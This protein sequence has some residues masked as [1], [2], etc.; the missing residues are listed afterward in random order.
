MAIV[1]SRYSFLVLAVI[2]LSS[3]GSSAVVANS[4]D[5]VGVQ[6]GM[7]YADDVGEDPY[8]TRTGDGEAV[9]NDLP[10]GSDVTLLQST[11]N[12]FLPNL[13]AQ[14]RTRDYS[15]NETVAFDSTLEL[16]PEDVQNYVVISSDRPSD[17]IVAGPLAN[18][19]DG[20]VVV[21]DDNVDAVTDEI[22]DANQVIKVGNFERSTNEAL[23]PFVT[24]SITAGNRF[25]LSNQ[26][27]DRVLENTGTESVKLSGGR[28]LESSMF[29]ESNPVLLTGSNS[30][31]EETRDYAVNNSEIDGAV[32]IGAE[33][34]TVA[35]ELDDQAD[36][37]GDDI[38]IFVKYGQATPGGSRQ[39]QALS[40]FPLP[41]SDMDIVITSAQYVPEQELFL[42]TLRNPSDTDGFVRNSIV[43]NNSGQIEATLE[44]QS[45]RF[46][47]AGSTQVFRYNLSITE[48]EALSSQ[49]EFTTSFGTDEGN[50]NTFVESTEENVFG[51]PR[52][53]PI[54]TVSIDD[55]T[56]ADIEAVSFDR[57]ENRFNV[58]LNNT[59]EQSFA[60]ISIRNVNV[61]GLNTTI[62]SPLEQIAASS[63]ENILLRAN[64]SR[65]D[66]RET[67]QITVNTRYG[68]RESFL[69]N[70]DT[71]TARLEVSDS[72]QSFIQE[73]TVIIVLVVLV[74]LLIAYL[75]Y[76]LL[77]TDE[78]NNS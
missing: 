1:N 24:E 25:E 59:Q 42:A 54:S 78:D 64:L 75:I 62:S 77:R 18:S 48:Q 43:I 17:V 67:D 19:I 69:I 20:W 45:P 44:D 72:G 70:T 73:N 28:F 53:L 76:I 34:A 2:V 16:I 36:S 52:I 47:P 60:R 5:W 6:A 40:L 46:I 12:A 29:T 27:A 51:P 57:S 31:A 10:I 23:E 13:D 65:D 8:F 3:L 61:D 49:A 58:T 26:V 37:V 22:E 55:N 14:I 15:L 38:S 11:E 4:Q 9:I 63:A 68:E 7:Q 21:V 56:Q 71:A 33:M 66:I 50:L 35:E 41:E 39:V 30:L 74:A 32:A